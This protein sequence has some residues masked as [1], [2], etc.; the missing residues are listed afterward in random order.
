M[1]QQ[2]KLFKNITGKNQS[3]MSDEISSSSSESAES[4][5]HNLQI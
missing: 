4:I 2:Q 3:K 5:S 1:I